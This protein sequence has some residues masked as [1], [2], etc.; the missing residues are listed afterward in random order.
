M[1]KE[2]SLTGGLVALVDDE[3]WP[4]ISQHNWR[5]QK[6]DTT[7]YALTGASET[8]WISLHRLITEATPDQTVDHKD[9]DGLNNRRSNLRVCTREQ[10]SANRRLG[11]NNKSG[12]KGVC[13]VRKRGKWL[14]QI[15]VDKK[16][17]TLGAFADPWEAA[18]AYNKAALA[19]WGEFA[20]LNVQGGG[21]VV[22]RHAP[23]PQTEPAGYSNTSIEMTTSEVMWFIG[24]GSTR[25]TNAW[26]S[27]HGIKAVGRRPGFNGENV[28]LRADVEQAKAS[29]PGQGKGGGRGKHRTRKTNRK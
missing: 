21:V 3:D 1:V 27:R 10:N 23:L 26:L 25:A 24:Y 9:G 28:Y 18:Q 5:A 11:V 19:A 6:S 8:A 15:S 2:I 22:M 20:L 14:A 4:L 12:Y 17:Y 13:W 29:M 16:H 7:Y